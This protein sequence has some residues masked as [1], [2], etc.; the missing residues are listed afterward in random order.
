MIWL[1]LIVLTILVLYLIKKTY[2]IITW[3]E[4]A[5]KAFIWIFETCC[6]TPSE[7]AWPPDDPP[8][9]P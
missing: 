9:F 8:K 5:Q 6:K 4:K 1:W 2:E 7:G 3:L